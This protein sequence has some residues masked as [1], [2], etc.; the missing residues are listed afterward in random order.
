MNVVIE[1][2]MI[3]L[4]GC[5]FP[6]Q[7]IVKWKDCP[8]EPNNFVGWLSRRKLYQQTIVDD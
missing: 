5:W 6:P 3:G 1:V 4:E 8:Y 2:V 7:A